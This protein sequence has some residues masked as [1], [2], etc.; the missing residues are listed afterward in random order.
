ME[1]QLAELI[2]FILVSLSSLALASYEAT[3]TVLSRSSLEKLVEAGIPRAG[4]MLRIHEPRQRLQL[5][6]RVG[7]ALAAITLTIAL[8]ALLS[9]YVTPP[10]AVIVT[11]LVT[12]TV[13][14]IAAVIRRTRFEEEG[15][16][17]RIP[18]LAVTYA[19]L[20]ALLLPLARL[21]ELLPIG[22][23]SEED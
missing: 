18:S 2:I 14:L 11:A 9:G 20:H 8:Q 1:P 6:A 16:D 21:L 10:I 23:S 13:F 7:Q 12:A 22:D 19:P 4:L 3:F 17:P 5:M 15:E